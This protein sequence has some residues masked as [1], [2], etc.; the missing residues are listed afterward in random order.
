[1]M[2][3]SIS[4][5]SENDFDLIWP[6]FKTVVSTQDT[7]IYPC[8]ISKSDAFDVWMVKGNTPYI[9]KIDDEVVG[10]Y[11]IRPNKI[12][13]GAH[14]CNAGFMVN[15]DFRKQGIGRKM[16][17]HALEEAKNLGFKAMQ[18]NVVVSTNEIAFKLWK[19]LGFNVIGSV[20]KAF[21]HG[22]KGLVDIYIMHRF[23]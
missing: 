7:Y 3:L 14:V 20:P 18:F 16:C 21:N 2:R 13:N 10:T 8:D 22:Q 9:A 4:P 15:P 5:A 1:M 23:L 12:G 19:S 6:I 11:T 17:E